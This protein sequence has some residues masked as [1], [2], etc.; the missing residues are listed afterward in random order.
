MEMDNVY[1]VVARGFFFET[2]KSS[3]FLFK[4]LKSCIVQ[5]HVYLLAIFSF[6]AFIDALLPP[7][8]QWNHVKQ[9]V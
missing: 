1:Q 2:N 6:A 4:Y 9:L 8:D 7:V 5:I 3:V